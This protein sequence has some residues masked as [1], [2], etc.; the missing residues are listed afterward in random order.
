M[1]DR[2][3]P[4]PSAPTHSTAEALDAPPDSGVTIRLSWMSLGLAT[5]LAVEIIG[6]AGYAFFVMKREME[7][8]RLTERAEAALTENY[9][10]L[11]SEIIQ[12]VHHQAPLVAEQMSNRLLKETPNARLELEQFTVRHL[13]QGFDNAFELSADEFRQWLRAN[14]D[15]IEDAF[16]Q[17][18]Q[19]PE[20]AKLLV[21]DTEASLE[22]QLGLD[23]RDQARLALEVYGVLNEKLERLA[24]PSAELSPQ[25]R[26]ERRMIRLLRALVQ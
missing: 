19:A 9:A 26:L 6:L 10:S 18:E 14:H 20:D 2:F 13:E 21:M 12:Q 23:L 3:T 17:I 16:V 11:R 4:P 22:E 25:E 24:L 7:P 8:A 15:A 1:S 5:L